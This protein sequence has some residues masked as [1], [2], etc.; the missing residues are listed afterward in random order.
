MYERIE[1]C[2]ICTNTDLRNSL[3]CKDYLVSQ[4]SFA[5]SICSSCGL[6]ITNPRPSKETISQFYDSSS[7]LSHNSD[8]SLMSR[9][10]SLAQRYTLWYKFR[11]VKRLAKPG[12]RLMDYGCGVGQFMQ[13]MQSNKYEVTG[14][15]PSD[16]GLSK[17]RSKEMLV[18]QTLSEAKESAAKFDVIT[19]WHVLE[20]VH[21]L[22][23]TIKQLK[24]LLNKDGHVVIAV[25]NTKSWDAQH[26]KENWA[27]YDVPRHLFHFDDENIK[28]LL[29][30]NRLSFLQKAPLYLDS[31]YIS[32]LSETHLNN[33]NKILKS[34]INGCKSNIYGSRTS[35]YSSMI[36][37]F[38][39]K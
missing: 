22:N 2:P 6:L 12:S 37:I 36:Y 33:G 23:T 38:Q 39:K 18:Y 26:Y 21:D 34:I 14:I 10:Y 15:E 24:K 28:M 25:P 5:I 4:Q 29:K 17:A 31:F 16:V 35:Q 1:E 30:S 3:I 32:L 8:G 27:A 7:Y 20:H 13:Y 19:L 11:L 9:L